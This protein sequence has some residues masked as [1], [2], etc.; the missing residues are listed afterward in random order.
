MK[1]A[2]TVFATASRVYLVDIP[3]G[4]KPGDATYLV[5][6]TSD[7]SKWERRP[8]WDEEASFEDDANMEPVAIHTLLPNGDIGD[9]IDEVEI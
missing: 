7:T 8:E 4:T 6:A 9:R 2:V 1:V 3:D 5:V